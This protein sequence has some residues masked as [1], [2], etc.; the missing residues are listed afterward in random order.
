M[1]KRFGN[2]PYITYKILAEASGVSE[3]T[4]R[5]YAKL[6]FEKLEEVKED[7]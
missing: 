4:I 3:N 1:V 5:K 7:D 6:M 2:H